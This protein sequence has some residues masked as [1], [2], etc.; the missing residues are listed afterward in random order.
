[1]AS[2]DLL[3]AGFEEPAHTTF[4]QGTGNKK[5]RGGADSWAPLTLADFP[6]LDKS[7][8]A[9]PSMDDARGSQSW[10]S[11]QLVFDVR[12]QLLS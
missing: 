4:A 9:E 11:G 12:W 5:A 7:Q 3:A 6:C 1:M 10:D 2:P 8:L